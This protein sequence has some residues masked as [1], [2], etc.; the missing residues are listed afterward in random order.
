MFELKV[1]NEQGK[2][3]DF[4]CSSEYIVYKIDGLNPAKANITTS[5]NSTMDGTVV[6][7]K[8]VE[9]R[10]IVLYINITRDI[11]NNRIRL[12]EY[13]TSKNEVILYFKNQTRNVYIKGYV[14]NVEIDFFSSN[15]NMQVSILC[16]N[17][18]FKDIE[19]NYTSFS[20]LQSLFEFDFSLPENGAVFSEIVTD[21]RTVITNV[22]DVDTGIIITI[23]ATGT[24]INPVI[25]DAMAR[26]HMKLNITLVDTDALIINT[27]IGQKGIQLVRN[28]VSTNAMGYLVPD[29]TWLILSAG[30]NIYTYS[31]DKGADDMQ[32]EFRTSVLYGGV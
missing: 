7:S 31:A 16:P 17:P 20:Q 25:Y 2:V 13:F 4:A 11:E 10:N 26:T 6:N 18:Y 9:N 1:E 5:T 29:S 30:D 12:Y 15:Q 27:N 23:N 28:G 14:E 19:D 8:R 22:G 3:L 21:P 32:V 24:V